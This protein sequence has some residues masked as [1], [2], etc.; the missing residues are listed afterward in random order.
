MDFRIEAKSIENHMYLIARF[1][2]GGEKRSGIVAQF[3]QQ[4]MLGVQGVV[5]DTEGWIPYRNVFHGKRT[6]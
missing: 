6:F 3:E 2:S 5:A 1:V 4:S